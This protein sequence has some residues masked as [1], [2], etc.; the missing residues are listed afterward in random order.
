LVIA[1]SVQIGINLIKSH[2]LSENLS[3]LANK[4]IAFSQIANLA[5]ENFLNMDDQANMWVGLYDF[6][7]ESQLAQDTYNQVLKAESQLNKSLQSAENIAGNSQQRDIVKKTIA[8]AR[9]Y[10]DYFSEVQ[11]NY[12]NHRE[13]T[14]IM[15]VANAEAS[16]QL[17]SDLQQMKALADQALLGNISNVASL[18][19]GNLY[20][21]IAA[22]IFVLLIAVVVLLP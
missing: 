16:N 8:D 12:A 9:T 1:I 22:G 14:H 2:Q 6:P 10:E 18:N 13:A 17:T 21:S 15:Y 5:N 7:Q 20:T 4:D 11:Q 19:E 3:Q